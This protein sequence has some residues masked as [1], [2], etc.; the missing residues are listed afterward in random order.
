MSEIPNSFYNRPE[1]IYMTLS[2]WTAANTPT[3][4]IICQKSLSEK[5]KEIAYMKISQYCIPCY[6]LPIFLLKQWS[7]SYGFGKALSI[8]RRLILCKVS[9]ICFPQFSFLLLLYFMLYFT[10]HKPLVFAMGLSILITTV[11]KI[12]YIREVTLI[13]LYFLSALLLFNFLHL[14][15]L[16]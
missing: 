1:D 12:F 6:L 7:F 10:I 5:C 8:L 3:N 16:Y 11:R 9:C 15:W 2:N 4:R 13:F 14:N